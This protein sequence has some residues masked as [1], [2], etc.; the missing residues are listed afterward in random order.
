[1]QV[2]MAL[3]Y[4]AVLVPFDQPWFKVTQ[5]LLCPFLNMM[6]GSE[7]RDRVY[8]REIVELRGTDLPYSILFATK[9]EGDGI[10]MI[11]SDRLRQI[12]H[13]I[14]VQKASVKLLIE[15]SALWE[16]MHFQ[17]VLYGPA[18]TAYLWTPLGT[19]YRYNVEI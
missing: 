19:A 18:L 2:T 13:I 12:A 15:L 6:R 14:F 9:V 7:I 1:M 10:L 3:T 17:G 4:E 5:R 16:L 11:S 8:R